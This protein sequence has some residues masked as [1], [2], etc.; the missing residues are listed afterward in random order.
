MLLG[1]TI[2]KYA[3]QVTHQ[4]STSINAMGV[5]WR[6]INKEISLIQNDTGSR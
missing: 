4:S 6:K 3:I 5:F 2:L 1:R